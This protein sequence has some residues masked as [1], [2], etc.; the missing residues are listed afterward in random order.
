VL[1]GDHHQLPEI[2]AGGVFAAAVSRRGDQAA[3]LTINRRQTAAW[4]QTALDHLRHGRALEGF[5]AYQDHGRVELS[6][7]TAESH[8]AAVEAWLAAHRD[9]DDAIIL[10]AT[11][12]ETR[13]LN[14]LARRAVADELTGPVHRIAERDFQ[15]GDRIVLLRN[16]GHQHDLDRDERCRVDNGM[17]ATVAAI[18]PRHGSFDITLTNGRRVRLGHDY[19]TAGWV[20]HGYAT[21]V[22][23]AQGLTCDQMFL[24]GPDGLYREAVYVA[25]SRARHG[26]H[27]FATSRQVAELTERAHTAGIPLPSEHADELDHDLRHAVQ[28]SRAK[29]LA[30]HHE[31]LLLPISRL[32][33]AIPLDMLW[34]RSIE[35]RGVVRQLQAGGHIN[36]ATVLTEAAQARTH[37]QLMH[38][39]GRVHAADWD[40]IGTIA[41]ID[42]RYGS[43][44]VTFTSE[45]G[46][47]ATRVLPW[48]HLQPI[49]GPDPVE[50]TATAAAFLDTLDTNAMAGAA[51][52][53]ELLDGHGIGADEPHTI[54][55]AIA[56]R[57][58]Q[59]GRRLAG[60]RP[61]WLTWWYGPR[62]T[63][64]AGAQVWDDEISQLAAWRDARQLDPTTPGYG[65]RPTR[66]DHVARWEAH[67]DRSLTTRNWLHH[68][69][70]QLEPPAP[71][72]VDMV[73]V[74]ARL[75]ELDA[76]LATAPPDQ[77]R[78]ITD[79]HDG[80]LTPGD[81]H[82][83]LVDAAATQGQRRQWILEHWPHV[84]EH[85]ELTRVHLNHDPLAHWPHAIPDDTAALL[86]ALA[87]HSV[88]TPELA[89]IS[90]S[91]GSSTTPNP[92]ATST[93]SGNG[94]AS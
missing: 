21:T 17:V 3:Q 87:D 72:T 16:D 59:L 37:R 39:G 29:Q 35:I 13:A 23:K 79:L 93:S 53:N 85:A 74:R 88:D 91:T 43:A 36:A 18:D 8:T 61:D 94:T 68:H 34:A 20:D 67:L 5:T 63:D 62:P 57:R 11:R 92:N 76:I 80:Q 24:V 40:N 27:V 28:T 65:P 41:A 4:E 58:Q 44:S 64:P 77:Q 19:L 10:A 86:D 83:A 25:M 55:A 89:A 90:T 52:W 32:A 14:T 70:P 2:T 46:T 42:D 30:H 48:H 26:A 50:L 73:A 82:Q 71:A 47:T 7:T 33:A 69:H 51:H 12:T 56:M 6:A 60:D 84:V 1:V 49:D 15:V 81:V 38:V 54:P 75:D 45:A 78:I 22:H 66:V 9:G 31:P